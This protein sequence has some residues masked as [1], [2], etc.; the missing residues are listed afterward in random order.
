MDMHYLTIGMAGLLLFYHQVTTWFPLYPWN[1]TLK[2]TKKEV[3]LEGVTNGLLMGT[4]LTCLII[5]NYNFYHYYPLF[6]YPFLLIGEIFQWWMPY[7]SDKFAKSQVNF[8]YN[9]RFLHTTKLIPH[10]EG[11]RTPDANHITLHIITL[12][13]VILVYLDLLGNQ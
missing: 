6:Y 9:A 13:T 12:I 10:R 11:K 3:I 1:D 8:E 5:G 7:W 4:G 2:Y